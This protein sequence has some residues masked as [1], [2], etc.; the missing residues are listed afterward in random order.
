MKSLQV[1]ANFD[2]P[3]KKNYNFVYAIKLEG[4]G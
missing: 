3:H 1:M 4:K 2:W